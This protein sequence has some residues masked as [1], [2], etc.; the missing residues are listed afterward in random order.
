[1]TEGSWC[2]LTLED[3][4]RLR[5]RNLAVLILILCMI[6]VPVMVLGWIF[7][8]LVLGDTP[9][10]LQIWV[11]GSFAVQWVGVVLMMRWFK[12]H[13]RPT[14]ETHIQHQGPFPAPLEEGLP[15]RRAGQPLGG[16]RH[17]RHVNLGRYDCEVTT[18]RVL[19][20][21]KA[22]NDVWR[23]ERSGLEA[24][25]RRRVNHRYYFAV[26]GLMVLA[27]FFAAVFISQGL[28]V[29]VSQFVVLMT[30][31]FVL[32]ISLFLVR[33]FISGFKVFLFYP[34]F[35]AMLLIGIGSQLTIPMQGMDWMFCGTGMVPYLASRLFTGIWVEND[36]VLSSGGTSVELKVP[37]NRF[38]SLVSALGTGIGQ[39]Q[40]R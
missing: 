1:M 2:P 8:R 4:R 35:C 23:L 13:Q 16:A 24:V 22:T 29:G 26:L 30:G 20:K 37:D 31:A 40:D 38:R 32:M 14:G 18:D 27:L 33:L 3:L 10:M 34:A 15:V 19:V 7:V 28:D 25:S 17:K 6:T 12:T 9:G 39:L 21:D 5:M 36:L 11:V